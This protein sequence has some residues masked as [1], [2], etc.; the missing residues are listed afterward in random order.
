[1]MINK[2]THTLCNGFTL[3][4]VRI[5]YRKA[6]LDIHLMVE[7]DKFKIP[8]LCR[9]AESHRRYANVYKLFMEIPYDKN[10]E[11][12]RLSFVNEYCHEFHG[13]VLH[14]GSMDALVGKYEE[15]FRNTPVRDWP[16]KIKE[17]ST[18]F[19][20]RDSTSVFKYL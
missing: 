4:S 17:L 16:L 7:V 9:M 20:I 14:H 15:Q 19:S 12:F 3:F 1:M 11:L 2:D 18:C 13:K 8:S 6:A 5:D 10:E